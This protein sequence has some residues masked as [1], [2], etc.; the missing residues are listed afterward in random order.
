MTSFVGKNSSGKSNVLRALNLF[1]N[2]Q[3]EPGVPLN[4]DRDFHRRPKR[5]KEVTV[6]VDFS[7]PA[8]FKFR[9]GLDAL[10]KDLTR[11]FTISKKWELGPQQQTVQST[12]LLVDGK[13]QT[14]GV[15]LADQFLSLI[16]FRYIPNRTV[17]V[18]IL[19]AESRSIATSI[20][21][22]IRGAAGAQDVLRALKS[23][24][25]NLLS[26]ATDAMA[27][28]GAP[29][30]ELA[31][32]TAS[33]LAEMLAVSGF[34][35]RGDHGGIVRDEAWGA[36]SQAFFLYQVLKAVD[37]TYTRSFGWRQAAVWGVEEPE[38]GLHHDLE[39]RLAAELRAWSAD[40]AAK[41]QVLLT[42]HSPAFAMASDAGYWISLN[43]GATEAARK[44]VPTLVRDAEQKGVSGWVQPVLAFPNNPV[45]LVEGE[46]DAEVLTHVAKLVGCTR[47][48]F[49][50][51]PQLDPAEKGAG[52]DAITV[53]LRR[54]G[55][56]IVNRP[57]ECPLIV[58]FDWEVSRTDLEAARKAYGSGA[59]LAVFAMNDA[60]CSSELGEDFRGIERFYPP[61][62]V[63]DGHR[64]GE[65][66]IGEVPG[67]PITISASQLSVAKQR[68]RHR[69]LQHADPVQLQPLAK[70]MADVEHAVGLLSNPQLPL[71]IA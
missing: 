54:H 61:S 24:A 29:L 17:P 58:L 43:S 39:T 53:Y 27:R 11:H 16:H 19:R 69:L 36:G 12:T 3:V 30:T 5:K 20:V 67:A 66:A 6:E 1:F 46:V 55:G 57:R 10:Q 71:G 59:G 37:T 15:Q 22:K 34:Q 35:A 68:L 70:V 52:K 41:L 28:T 26:D 45:V 42:T 50:A 9:S 14:S 60:H 49:L 48:R 51:L 62:I 31:M 25:D 38:S 32:S 44:E 23:G 18:D 47:L 13:Q 63:R 65:F 21:A 8:N 56:L 33:S 64:A 4:L 40:Q 7:V 2:D